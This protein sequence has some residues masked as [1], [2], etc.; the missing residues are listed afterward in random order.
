M[1]KSGID[2][3]ALIEQFSQATAQQGEALRQ[4]VA[5]ATLKALQGRELT[6]QNVR[7]VLKAVTQ[8]ASAGAA[9]NALPEV[10]VSALLTQAFEGMDGALLKAVEAQRAALQQ[11]VDRGVDLRD[12][13]M[14]T[15]LASLEK[16]ED[17]FF[18]TVG[19][20]AHAAGQPL[21]GPWDQVLESMKLK[22][23]GTG[24]QAS[25]AMTDLMA[26]TRTAL[27]DGRALG[28]QA[29]Q[30]LLEGYATL[31]SGVLIGMSQGLRGVSAPSPAPAPSSRARKS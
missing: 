23:T 12:K 15:A 10:D 27:R 14:K 22:G 7:G 16:M 28:L 9:R 31:V 30:A 3:Q 5:E 6:L 29:S 11:F 17:V 24:T 19:K 1:L 4:A 13:Q 8:A 25:A 26:Q 18:D 2:Q 21:A 20:G